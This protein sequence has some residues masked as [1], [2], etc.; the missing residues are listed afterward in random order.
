M[1]FAFRDFIVGNLSAS[2]RSISSIGFVFSSPQEQ[3]F[4]WLFGWVLEILSKSRFGQCLSPTLYELKV[5][6]P[7][8]SVF[9][10][11]WVQVRK[12]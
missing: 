8:I 5:F 12:I 9:I 10:S 4:G 2:E 7:I 3:L 6:S 1:L 11:V